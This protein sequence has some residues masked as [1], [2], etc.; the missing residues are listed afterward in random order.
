MS[1]D[2]ISENSKKFLHLLVR[3]RRQSASW[4]KTIKSRGIHHWFFAAVQLGTAVWITWWL[5]HLPPPGYAAGLLAFLAANMTV[6]EKMR[7]WHKAGWMLLIGACLFVEFRAVERDRFQHDAEVRQTRDEQNRQFAQIA[8]GIQDSIDKSQ[9]QFDATMSRTSHVLNNITGGSSYAVV[10]PETFGEDKDLPLMIENHGKN[11][12]TGVSVMFSL[13]GAFAGKVPDYIL[14]AVNNRAIVGTIGPHERQWLNTSLLMDNLAEVD[15]D[16][17]HVRCAYILI[18]AQNFSSQEFLW[19]KRRDG[20]W[21]F[22]YAIY[23]SFT[24]KEQNVLAKSKGK[25]VP[26][27]LLEKIDWTDNLN[28]LRGLRRK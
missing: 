16:G 8:K 5:K 25:E 27:N 20:K 21:L 6:H 15:Q 18:Y 10:L 2:T 11:V 3:F 14:N 1:T 12:L 17:E 24:K 4:L 9:Q 26:N 23:R 22:K 19:F 13:W 28:D 7:N